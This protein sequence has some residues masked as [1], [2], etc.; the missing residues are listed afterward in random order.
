M[1]AELQAM[2]EAFDQLEK[3]RPDPDQKS[4]RLADL[5]RSPNY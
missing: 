2:D 5:T 3:L 4:L 1:A